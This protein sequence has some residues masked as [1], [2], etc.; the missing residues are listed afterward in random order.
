VMRD[1][2]ERK[3]EQA[4]RRQ[5][6]TRARLASHL[7]SIGEMASGIAHEINNP[8]TAVIG[9]SQLLAQHNLPAEVK[10]AVEQI[11]Q[12]ATRVAGIV[13]RLLTFARQHTPT[14]GAVDLN[15]VIRSTLALRAYALKAANIRV[16][17]RLDPLLP[18]TIADGKQMQQVILNLIMNAETAM[19]GAHQGGELVLASAI[20]RGSILLTVSDDGP[21]IPDAIQDRIFDPFFTTRE[22]GQGTGLGLSICHGIVNEHGGRIWVQS[23][24]G[25]GAAFFVEVPVISE[26]KRKT[27]SASAKQDSTGRKTRILVVD[28]EPSVLKLLQR[29]LEEAGHRVDA[30]PDGRSALECI[31]RERYGLILLD[32]RMPEMSGMEVYEKAKEIADSVAQRIIFLTG[33]IMA[34]ELQSLLERTGLPFLNKPFQTQE[35]LQ[36]ISLQLNRGPNP[37]PPGG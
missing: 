15:E 24:C 5:L 16:T 26:P 12:G 1:I 28:D 25:K 20:N 37:R 33:D 31:A 13:Q 30:A 34:P 9:Y 14:R 3:E 29:L 32:V 11:L 36:T 18:T 17:T 22:E 35:L 19:K 8:L 27:E 23:E 6:E 4:Q 10:E 7:A 21:G 2:T